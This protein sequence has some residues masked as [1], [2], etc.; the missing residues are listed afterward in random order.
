MGIVKSGLFFFKQK[1]CKQKQQL[2]IYKY[3]NLLPVLDFFFDNIQIRI[4]LILK[5][6]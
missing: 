1:P 2:S 4:N 3:Y 6:S 5:N